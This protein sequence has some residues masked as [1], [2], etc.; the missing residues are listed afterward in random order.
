VAIADELRSMAINNV[1]QLVDCPQGVNLVS[2][3][4]VFK[5]K[6]LPNG[7]IDKLKARLV[8]RGFT[9][10][11]GIDYDE[12]FASVVRTESLRILLAIAAMEDLEVHQLDVI[13]AYLAGELEEEIYMAPP[14]GL[15]ITGSKVCRLLKG[16]YGLKQSARVWN[17]RIGAVLKKLGLIAIATDAS[18]WVN[19][20]CSIILAL[21]VDDIVLL[22]RQ[23]QAL[24]SVKTALSKAFKMKDLGPISTVLGMRVRRDRARRLLWID[25]SHYI[26]DILE[27]FQYAD[28]RP[29]A[30]PADGYEQLS[31][32]APE[33]TPF[34]DIGLYQ[35]ALGCLNWLVRG[36]RPDLAFVVHKLSQFCHQPYRQHWQGV[37]RVFRYL[38]HTQTLAIQYGPS[39]DGLVGYTDTDYAADTLDRHSTMGY[40]F[41]LG[42]AVT[43][44]ARKQQS[45]STSTTEA[46]YVGFCN[47]AK[48]AVW[49]RNLLQQIGRG[50]YAEHT[51]RLYGD[52]Q[53]A[54]KLV[55]NP[56]FHAR[57]KHIDVQYHCVREL[58]EDGIVSVDYIPT[59]DMIADCLTKPLKKTKL[60]ANLISLGLVEDRG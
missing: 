50:A 2:C 44:S 27:E 28:C 8:A 48:E 39:T 51:T 19:K 17:R 32:A 6:R 38:K 58:V 14:Q 41:M 46:E 37:L 40:V 11:Y 4:W 30:T 56:E 49:L 52:N 22:A 36:T 20:D 45:I 33:D 34:A 12:T 7:H 1:W 25:Q 59:A 16:L 23:M 55:A 60:A 57:S 13:T 43:W 21:Y 53:S 5:V 42:G 24:E 10:R 54:L 18:I 9:Q 31:P 35:K 47:A 29:V 3:K 26:Q 15:P